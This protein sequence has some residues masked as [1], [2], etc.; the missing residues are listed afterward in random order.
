VT[1]TDFQLKTL[2][3]PVNVKR[4]G[5]VRGMAHM[6]AWDIRRQLIRVFG[7]GG[8]SIDT[9]A[10]DLVT[11][12]EKKAGDRSRWTV[13]YRAQVRLTVYGVDGSELSHWEDGAAG[14][15]VNQPSL[16]DAHD[17]AMKTAL[18]QAMK[19]CA[20]NLGDQFGLS[21]YN[22]GSPA[23]VV[24]WSA[25]HPPKEADAPETPPLDQ[26]PQVQPEPAPQAPTA[27]PETPAEPSKPGCACGP[28]EVCD[29]CGPVTTREERRDRE[30]PLDPNWV[31]ARDEMLSAARAVNF[32]AG[33]AAQFESTF[34]HGIEQGTAAE[35]LEATAL[36][37]G[38]PAA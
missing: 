9:L 16:G 30:T 25:A 14:D 36:M 12:L 19:R 33:L 23:P 31:T 10:L 27:V 29:I 2:L 18:S 20:V 5:Q 7:F 4:V 17:M 13:V 28:R 34:G 35:F 22:N 26:D 3:A 1:L 8:Y 32:E 24:Q 6:E 38:T 15:S 21:L 37:R 11:E